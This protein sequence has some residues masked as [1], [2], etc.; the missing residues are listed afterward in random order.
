M[1]VVILPKVNRKQLR[2]DDHCLY[3]LRHLVGK[4][5]PATQAVA[6]HRHSLCKAFRPPIWPS[7][8]FAVP[9]F[10]LKSCDDAI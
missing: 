4:C 3:K 1:Q 7:F 10:G 8:N 5:L 2:D 6:R 9:Y